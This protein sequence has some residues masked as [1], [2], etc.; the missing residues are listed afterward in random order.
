VGERDKKILQALEKLRVARFMEL[1]RETGL[2]KATLVR[3]LD[4]L[5][6]Y[7]EIIHEGKF[8]ALP[9]FRALLRAR[10]KEEVRAPMREE[11]KRLEV[12]V[13]NVVAGWKKKFEG[14]CYIRP[15][16]LEVLMFKVGEDYEDMEARVKVRK[17]AIK[18]GWTPPEIYMRLVEHSRMLGRGIGDWLKHLGACAPRIQVA[19][20][21][22]EGFNGLGFIGITNSKVYMK[23][24]EDPATENFKCLKQHLED[25]DPDLLREWEALKTEALDFLTTV[26]CL[27]DGIRARIT[28]F[29]ASYDTRKESVM[30]GNAVEAAYL[31][32]KRQEVGDP[33][34][35]EEGGF[36][37][38]KI[39]RFSLLHTRVRAKAE[40]FIKIFKDEISSSD[41][42]VRMSE[43]IEKQR[44]I[45][46]KIES[47]KGKL[48]EIASKVNSGTYYL[49]GF[50]DNCLDYTR[51][52]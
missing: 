49:K 42:H 2:P 19:H 17:L 24:P 10:M 23:P 44:K 18:H 4:N 35:F 14:L 34:L 5:T 25:A 22:L 41:A 29:M 32:L 27:V 1:I 9:K 43:I 28:K 52:Y 21:P 39:S 13:G 7:G 38:V 40:R 11:L 3:G 37:K 20:T 12:K 36:Y 46:E 6:K 33:I 45:T 16:P 26:K 51:S 8:Y 31:I 30:L 48:R 15:L 50:C 47:F